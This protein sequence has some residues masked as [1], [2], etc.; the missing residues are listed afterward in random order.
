M[1][2]PIPD[3]N[4]H[5]WDLYTNPR[6]R[7]T[8]MSPQKSLSIFNVACNQSW[9]RVK[10]VKVTKTL[11]NQCKSW[12]ANTRYIHQ[13][14]GFSFDLFLFYCAVHDQIFKNLNCLQS[15]NKLEGFRYLMWC[16][17]YQKLQTSEV[18]SETSYCRTVNV[19]DAAD[20]DWDSKC[21]INKTLYD[22]SVSV[23]YTRCLNI[24]LSIFITLFH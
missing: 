5:T 16:L 2:V 20:T 9:V 17:G 14:K 21:R 22:W 4:C 13:N 10:R 12:R 24:C 23:F 3:L 11:I 8:H 15:F 1:E 18:L 7:Q 6:A 19:L